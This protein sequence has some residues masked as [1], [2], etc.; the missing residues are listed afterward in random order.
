MKL[1]ITIEGVGQLLLA[2]TLEFQVLRLVTEGYLTGFD[3][4]DTGSYRFNIEGWDHPGVPVTDDELIDTP[5]GRVHPDFGYV[6]GPDRSTT[7]AT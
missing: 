5:E 2:D 1:T 6:D 3:S 7:P 4:N